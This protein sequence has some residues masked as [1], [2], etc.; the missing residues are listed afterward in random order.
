MDGSYGFCLNNEWVKTKINACGSVLI[1]IFLQLSKSEECLQ[2]ILEI[3][4]D[5]DSL[6]NRKLYVI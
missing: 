6:L 4:E 2:A 1:A 5:S 3:P